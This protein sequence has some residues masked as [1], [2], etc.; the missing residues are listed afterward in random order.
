MN[1]I[2]KYLNNLKPEYKTEL[3]RIRKIIKELVPEVAEEMSY[4]MPTFKY[5]GKILI[6]IAAFK[7]HMSLF[8]TP[9]PIE[10]LQEKLTNFQI[11]KG[12]IKFTLENN[13]SDSLVK[14][15]VR[16]RLSNIS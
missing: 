3:E 13:V 16:S 5:K 7:D 11:S 4:G 6:H 8:P 15:I 12:T 9:G 2:D 1:E 14:D 10:D